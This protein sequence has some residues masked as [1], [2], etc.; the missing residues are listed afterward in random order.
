MLKALK[1][2]SVTPTLHPPAR[3]LHVG[4]DL[5]LVS[6]RSMVLRSAGY[7]VEC[8]Y[9]IEDA[10]RHFLSADFDLVLLCHSLSEDERQHF[11]RRIREHDSPTPILS[12]GSF[13]TL[14]SPQGDCYDLKTESGPIGLL[15]CIGA[16][17]HK[18]S[19]GPKYT[20]TLW[21][22]YGVM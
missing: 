20:Q 4:R 15:N 11:V 10:V 12:I 6:T 5:S 13:Y 7:N 16:T 3:I 1:G 18:D 19:A 21:P 17:L 2:V 9:T 22:P 8:K 14:N